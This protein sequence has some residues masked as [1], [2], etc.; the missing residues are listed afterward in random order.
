MLAY[1]VLEFCLKRNAASKKL[2]KYAPKFSL[3]RETSLVCCKVQGSG[4][5]W[6]TVLLCRKF[7][8][9]GMNLARQFNG[10]GAENMLA[11]NIRR[12][13]RTWF[14]SKPLTCRTEGT[15]LCETCKSANRE[16]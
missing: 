7:P 2:A 1:S 13:P 15:S 12:V 3:I 16:T 14:R 8:D 6:P 9:D 5:G 4:G 10:V 11:F